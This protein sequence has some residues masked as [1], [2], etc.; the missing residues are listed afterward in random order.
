MSGTGRSRRLQS[1]CVVGQVALALML[2]IGAGLTSR[3]FGR[4]QEV[5]PGFD[6]KG[7]V[8]LTITLPD[9]TYPD[10]PGE[11]AVFKRILTRVQELAVTKRAALVS[12]LPLSGSKMFFDVTPEGSRVA[13]GDS[14]SSGYD[15][16]SPNYFA[17]MRIPIVHGRASDERD[18]ASAPGV[19]I[20]NEVLARRLWPGRDPL[21]QRLSIGDRGPNPRQVEGVVAEVHHDGL[22]QEPRSEVYVPY[23]QA[24]WSSM[25]LVARSQE[26]P[27]RLYGALRRAI[28]AVD[29]TLPIS[30][31]EP[32]LQVLADSISGRRFNALLLGIFAAL[33][34]T[35]AAAG[36]YGIMSHMVAERRREIGI[37]IA[38]GAGASDVRRLVLRRGLVLVLAGLAIGLPAALLLGRVLSLML[39]DVS[40]ADPLTFG[41]VAL[42]LAA[43]SLLSGYLPTVRALQVDPLVSMRG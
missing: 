28:W 43:V 40:A 2:S 6:P 25:T 41:A 1:V 10:R 19:C 5:K 31:A 14:P 15:A 34:L 24:G 12:T 21:G 39:F 9:K 18:G 32:M 16:V 13:P 8:T 11:A 27:A 42:A 20:V 35:L 36:L 3:S 17:L 30:Q 4:L 7:V 33:A 26:S 23:T 37:R 38:L 22:D 29:G